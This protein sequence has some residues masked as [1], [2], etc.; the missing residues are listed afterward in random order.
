[1]A[2]SSVSVTTALKA[3]DRVLQTP[4]LLEN[5][6][7]RLDPVTLLT[8]VRQVT[9]AW[10]SL[11]ETSPILQ[12]SSWQWRY[13]HVPAS[14]LNDEIEGRGWKPSSGDNHQRYQSPN[15]L[16]SYI[17][18]AVMTILD[19]P[20]DQRDQPEFRIA[21]D[22][23]VK[24]VPNVYL[25]LWRPQLPDNSIIKY[26]FGFLDPALGRKK[27]ISFF[28]TPFGFKYGG[29]PLRE[30]LKLALVLTIGEQQRSVNKRILE[31]MWVRRDDVESHM[32]SGDQSQ[33][34]FACLTLF[35]LR[36]SHMIGCT[37]VRDREHDIFDFGWVA[38]GARSNFSDRLKKEYGKPLTAMMTTDIFEFRIQFHIPRNP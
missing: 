12:W 37:R 29:L 10:K 30:L 33:T 23:A 22:N 19:F 6:L 21:L 2:A 15:W 13:Q 7:K 5:I 27:E 11:V 24:Q 20:E 9:P 1:M 8:T 16:E 14:V 32:Q 17:E 31:D 36:D 18:D 3:V 34:Q 26:H 4:E 38:E 35:H 25:E 28:Y